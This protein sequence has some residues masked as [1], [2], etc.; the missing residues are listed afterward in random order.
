MRN[1]LFLIKCAFKLDICASFVIEVSDKLAI[2]VQ[3]RLTY[4]PM[5]FESYI[6]YNTVLRSRGPA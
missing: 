6:L 5:E 1:L 4:E 2:Q 3:Q